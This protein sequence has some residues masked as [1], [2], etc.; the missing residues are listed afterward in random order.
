MPVGI[1]ILFSCLL[2]KVIAAAALTP[3]QQDIQVLILA[4]L[5]E[6]VAIIPLLIKLL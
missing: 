5:G 3:Q 4:L 1:N 6:D 2:C